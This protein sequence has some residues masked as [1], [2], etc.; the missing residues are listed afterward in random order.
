VRLNEKRIDRM[1]AAILDLLLEED[2]VDFKPTTRQMTG[3]L[4][5]FITQDLAIEDEI[6]Q[7]AMEKLNTYSRKIP[8]GS[9]EWMLLLAKHK[10]EIA[11]KRGYTL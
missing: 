4:A 9:T 1:A 10:D 5:R 6:T 2:L 8:E 3:E 11:A 7:E